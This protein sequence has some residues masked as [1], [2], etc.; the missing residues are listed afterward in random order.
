MVALN[1]RTEEIRWFHSLKACAEAFRVHRAT[2]H[3]HLKK[4]LSGTKQKDG[5]FFKYD[6]ETPF[7]I[8][9]PAEAPS[10]G[11]GVEHLVVL[12]KDRVSRKTIVLHNLKQ[13]S[14]LMGLKYGRLY[15]SLKKSGVYT[16]ASCELRFATPPA[17]PSPTLATILE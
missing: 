4:G 12:L 14:E 3:K 1:P 11:V 2:L 9:N 7:V 8:E 5:F 17:D 6:D 16:D 15:R 13:A 10:L